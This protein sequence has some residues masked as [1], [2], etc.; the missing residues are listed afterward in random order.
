[1]YVDG[2]VEDEVEDGMSLAVVRG[3]G[4]SDRTCN[5]NV[6]RCLLGQLDLR[7]TIPGSGA[8]R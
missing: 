1:M 3:A 4:Y 6:R 5:S 8:S 2:S 7:L